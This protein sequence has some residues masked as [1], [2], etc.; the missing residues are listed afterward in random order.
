MRAGRDVWLAAALAVVGQLDIWVAGNIEGPPAITVP[1]S[2]LLAVAVAFRRRAPLLALALGVGALAAQDVLAEP[3]EGLSTILAIMILGYSVGAELGLA[4][5]AGAAA[6]LLAAVWAAVALGG[7]AEAGDYAFTGLIAAVPWLIGRG[8]RRAE[9]DRDAR[10]ER[11]RQRHAEEAVADE[12]ERIA[13]ELHDVVAHGVSVMVV[14]AGALRQGLEPGRPEAAGLQAIESSGRE[15]LA[16]LRAMLQVLRTAE[17]DSEL[18]PQPGLGDLEPL[19]ERFREAGLTIECS[20]GATATPG[21]GLA[22]YR[23]IQESLTNV[24]KHGRH[25]TR[26]RVV[27]VREGDTI[28]LEVADDGTPAS[29]GDGGHGLIGMRERAAVYGGTLSAG[30]ALG[31]GW[32]VEAILSAERLAPGPG[33]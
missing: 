19:I 27:V 17:G 24:L 11:D 12:R 33:A 7:P 5:S 1:A 22:V 26:V 28:R 4:R 14:H 16:E 8:S 20:L 32:R 23:I 18:A 29:A 3:A 13:R 6:A 9:G 31:G 10:L 15:A 30:P 2:L 21:P 25:V